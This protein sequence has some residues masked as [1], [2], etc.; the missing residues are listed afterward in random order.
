MRG[1]TETISNSVEP[2][3]VTSFELEFLFEE[4]Q[5]IKAEIYN[6]VDPAKNFKDQLFVGEVEFKLHEVVTAKNQ[7][8]TQQMSNKKGWLTVNAEESKKS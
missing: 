8:L 1:R 2:M 5:T 6:E 3:F 4:Q 7:T